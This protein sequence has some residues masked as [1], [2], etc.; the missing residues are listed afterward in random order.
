MKQKIEVTNQTPKCL[1]DLTTVDP[2]QLSTKVFEFTHN[3]KRSK[4]KS[5]ISSN[6]K[7]NEILNNDES[8][9]DEDMTNS[10]KRYVQIK[11]KSFT[12][13]GTQ[14]VILQIVDISKTILYD[15]AQAKSEFLQMINVTVSH[16]MRNPLNAIL[17]LNAQLFI[18]VDEMGRFITEFK[19]VMSLQ[20]PSKKVAALDHLAVIAS[21]E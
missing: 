18:V 15:K 20:D 17:N 10:K 3:P 5:R 8:K 14:R 6:P 11:A 9:S 7:L 16:E 2:I 4:L 19:K 12:V 13:D 1:K 21:T